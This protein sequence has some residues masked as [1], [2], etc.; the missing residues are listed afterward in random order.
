[1]LYAD[2]IL[3]LPLHGLYTYSI[4]AALVQSVSVGSRVIVQFG[5]KKLYTAIVFHIHQSDNTN[6]AII[7]DITAALDDYPIV[8]PLQLK[9]WEWIAMYYI[10]SLGD[11]Y[12][13]A[14]PSSLKL[15]SESYVILNSDYEES[16]SLKPA[17]QKI[18]DNLSH[19]KV[20]KISEAAKLSGISNVIPVV[21]SL[22]DKGIVYLSEDIGKNYTPKTQAAVRFAKDFSEDELHALLDSLAKVKKQS[23]LLSI[24]IFL[25]ETTNPILKK[26]LLEESGVSDGVLSA[27]VQKGILEVYD[28]EVDRINY[29]VGDIDAA[30][31]LNVYQQKAYQEI[32]DSFESKDI[33]LLHGV[34]SS[35]KTEIYIQLIKDAIEKGRQVLYLLPEIALTTQITNRLKKVFGD[36]MAVYH[37]KFNDNERA[38]IWNKSLKGE[39]DLVLGARSAVL[40]PFKGLGLVIVDEEHEGSYKQQDPAPRYNARNV[41][42]VLA[43][44]CG[45]KIL[46]GTATPSVETYQNAKTG[47]YGLVSLTKRYDDIN[48][49]EIQVVNVKELRR[50]KQMKSILSPP[51]IDRM[52]TAFS[53]GE[54]VILFQNR[55][56]FASM[57]ECK[58]CSWTPRCIHCDVSLTY[59]KGQ[60][61]MICHY[62]GATYSVPSICPE[63]DTPTLDILGYGTERVEEEVLSQFPEARTARMDLDTTRT[64]KAYERIIDDFEMGKTDVLIGTQMVSKGLD[65]DNVSVVGIIN[66]DNMLNY[67]DF[68]AHERAFQLMM[69]VSGRA[70]RKNKQGLVILQTS[71]PGHPVIDYVR[72]NDYESFFNLQIEERKLFR[73]PPFYRLISIVMR[74]KDESILDH[75]SK[76]FYQSLKQSFAQRVYVP[77]KPPVSRVQSLYIRKILLKIENQLPIH[78]VR[79]ALAHHQNQVLRNPE[80]RSVLL[81]YDVDPV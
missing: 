16:E 32:Q 81:H 63:C 18:L 60:R 8:T 19:S 67:P 15:E 72:K 12:K 1:M 17:E 28:Y 52:T 43:D 21:K 34:T 22:V 54:Q 2:V 71:H 49:P 9:L 24:F 3:P 79:E 36:R 57:L 26:Q 80:F 42:M 20:Y 37:S 4:P 61:V 29:G 75:A 33:T 44:M 39:Y 69:Q 27:L 6:N 40:L 25:G 66:S 74:A 41:A 76:Q 65:F 35:G 48:L 47:R 5:K 38:E 50:K 10:C 30:Y 23:H 70:G 51:L 53:Q 14:L 11:V 13:A 77:V 56:G 46:L 62:C 68:R 45:A 58:T 59:H 78:K 55:R 31:T 64:K 73:Y 7:K